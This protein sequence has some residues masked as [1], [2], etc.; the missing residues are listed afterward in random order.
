M[1]FQSKLQI[2]LK[3]IKNIYLM[4]LKQTIKKWQKKL[5]KSINR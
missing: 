3:I 1:I 2:I 5:K 4:K